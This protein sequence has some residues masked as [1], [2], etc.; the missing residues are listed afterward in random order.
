MVTDYAC[1]SWGVANDHYDIFYSVVDR[2]CG[3]Q[4]GSDGKRV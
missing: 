3:E 1:S 4:V 2:A